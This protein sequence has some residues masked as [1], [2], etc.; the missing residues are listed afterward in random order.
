[1]NGSRRRRDGGTAYPARQQTTL[2]RGA[3]CPYINV[4]AA[5]LAMPRLAW[6]AHTSMSLR[7]IAGSPRRWLLGLAALLLLV[8][9][10]ATLRAVWLTILLLPDLVQAGPRPLTWI[11]RAPV[12]T[13]VELPYAGD[14]TATADLYVPRG[15]PL[16]WRALTRSPRPAVVLFVGI[17]TPRDYG[18]LVRL[19]DGLARGGAVVI[20][21]E[22]PH[23]LNWRYDALEADS[24]VVAFEYLA[25]LPVVDEERIGFAGFSVGG[26]L[27]LLAAADPRIRDRLAYVHAFGA[28]AAAGE[29]LAATTT[30]RVP[31]T[32]EP[33]VP[34]GVTR[35]VLQLKLLDWVTNEDDRTALTAVLPPPGEPW[36][37]AACPPL[38]TAEAA[39]FCRLAMGPEVAEQLVGYLPEEVEHRLRAISPLAVLDS[40]HAPVL[41]MH[42]RSD[43]FIPYT[44]SRSIAAALAQAGRPPVRYS[45]FRLFAHVLP[46]RSLP[47]RE[48]IP[49]VWRLVQ[50]THHLV[51]YVL[52]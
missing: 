32:G 38:A 34:D 5:G 46:G 14:R 29:L 21:P 20:V 36:Q 8:V 45:E 31:A 52:A 28:Y 17:D 30:Q 12:R 10:L 50:H 35:K 3:R 26:S 13:T 2:L 48:L 51:S 39:F 6:I 44:E 7:K 41:L 1:M 37:V 47:L 23:L 43:T 27:A 4:P 22:T 18:P 15:G 49:E 33:W 42:D 25:R 16:D 11:A 40:V 24:L 19:A 9:A